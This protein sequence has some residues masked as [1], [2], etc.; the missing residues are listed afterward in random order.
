MDAWKPSLN[1]LGIFATIH[2]L[3]PCFVAFREAQQ[4]LQRRFK[5]AQFEWLPFGIDIDTFHGGRDSRPIFAFWMGRRYEPL[6]EA[7]L[8]YCRS[9]NLRYVFR[10]PSVFPS[11]EELGDIA[12]QTKYF[13]VTP[14]DLDDPVKTGGFSPLVMRYMEGL[15]AGARLLGTLPK[16]GEYEE[17]LPVEAI[18]QVAPDGSDLARRLA[19]DADD[20]EGWAAVTRGQDLVRRHHSCAVRAE[21]IYDRIV[22]NEP[23]R[24]GR[25]DDGA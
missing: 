23:I 22:R 11:P 15:A 8:E 7:L 19:E 13:V 16:S 17:F 18:C 6:H 4:E 9:R 24:L 10:E 3:N 1:K 5:H 21:Q 12:S 20:A 14:P 2:R 25:V